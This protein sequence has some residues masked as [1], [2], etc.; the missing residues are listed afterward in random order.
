MTRYSQA[1]K[2]E[3]IRMVETSAL[4]VKQ[5]LAELDVARS[6]FYGWYQRYREQGFDGLAPQTAQKQQF[7]NRITRSLTRDSMQRPDHRNTSG[8]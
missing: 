6:T 8:G 1:E 5:T 7:S 3:I 4:S 2:M